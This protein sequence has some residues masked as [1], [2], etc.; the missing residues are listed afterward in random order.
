MAEKNFTEFKY[1]CKEFLGGLALNTLRAYGRK[2]GVDNPTKDKTKGVLI[3][4][5]VAVLAGEIAP[6]PRSNRGAPVKN[7]F[8]DPKVEEYVQ[9]LRV[10]YGVPSPQESGDVFDFDARLKKVKETP[11]VLTVEDPNA[12]E[13]EKD[14]IREIFKGQLETLNNVSMLLPLDCSDPA[15]KIIISVDLI[16]AHDLREGDVIT[17]YC[18]KRQNALVATSIL[19]VNDLVLGTFRRNKFDECM[20]V[21]PQKRMHFYSGK[22]NGRVLPKFFEWILPFGRGQRGLVLAPPKSGTSTL[23]LEMAQVAIKE[24]KQLKVLTLLV[25]QSPESIIQFRK[26]IKADNLLYTTYEDEPSRQV[27]VADFLLKRAKRYAENGKDVLLIVDSFNALS[28]AFN[29][30]EQSVGGK[31]L[32]GGLESKT[33]QYL[34]RYLGAARC[35]DK[36]GSITILGALATDT[37]NPADD[38]LKSELSTVANLEIYLDE[39]LAKRRIYPALDVS[40]C[41]GKYTD[42]LVGFRQSS[43]NVFIHSEYLPKYGAPKLFE[44]LS[45]SPDFDRLEQQAYKQIK[46]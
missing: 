30:T 17:C 18:E 23:L 44:L 10:L 40:S 37:G 16:R 25:D 2:I 3:A 13:L 14:G 1:A 12:K 35:L 39:E 20:A 24:N 36:G 41:G 4:D 34:K 43:F 8:V 7:D 6:K 32:A 9:T 21:E 45:D 46:K 27:F 26:F 5:I 28:R 29:D 19:T 31:V 22:E 15:V 33:L 38:L 42:K 11:F